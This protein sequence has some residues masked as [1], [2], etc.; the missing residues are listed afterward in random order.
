MAEWSRRIFPKRSLYL[1][2]HFECGQV[3]VVWVA[4]N[5]T[6]S[7]KGEDGALLQPEYR[8]EVNLASRYTQIVTPWRNLECI[9]FAQLLTL[10]KKWNLPLVW[11]L[12]CKLY[13]IQETVNELPQDQDLYKMASSLD[14]FRTIFTG[15]W[16]KKVGKSSLSV[17]RGIEH[18]QKSEK[19]LRYRKVAGALRTLLPPPS[20]LLA[21]RPSRRNTMAPS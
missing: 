2:R 5:P 14:A 17:I 4:P 6:N 20:H 3:L 10:E 12:S 21:P 1:L 7:A 16:K 15:R 19:L 18:L 8:V 13:R 11:F 9:K